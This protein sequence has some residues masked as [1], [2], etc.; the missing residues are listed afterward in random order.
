MVPVI[1]VRRSL[2]VTSTQVL[3]IRAG[4]LLADTIAKL[5]GGVGA[6]MPASGMAAI[7][8]V[9]ARLKSDELVIAARDCHGGIYRPFSARRGRGQFDVSFIDQSDEAT[10]SIAGSLIARLTARGLPWLLQPNIEVERN[11]DSETCSQIE[12]CFAIH[13]MFG[14]AAAFLKF[15]GIQHASMESAFRLEALAKLGTRSSW[16]FR[17]YSVGSCRREFADADQF[18]A[19]RVTAIAISRAANQK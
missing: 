13:R 11:E 15:G 18:K 8:L 9:L 2:G 17:G 6:V 10:L 5:G 14:A 1:P 12:P 3:R 7:D 19:G 4:D 16:G